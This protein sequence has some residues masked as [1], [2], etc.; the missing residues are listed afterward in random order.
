MECIG[1]GKCKVQKQGDLQE[2]FD[3]A[4]SSI[5]LQLSAVL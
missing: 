2:S 5:S 4:S 1:L 3:E